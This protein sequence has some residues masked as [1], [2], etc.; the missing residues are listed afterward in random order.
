MFVGEAPGAE[1]DRQGLPFVGRAGQLLDELLEGIGLTRDDVF[2][3]NVL[4]C[5]PPGNRDPQPD[6]IE[7]CWP[8]LR[9]PDRADPA[10]RDRHARQLRDQAAHRQPDRDH[11]GPRDARRST[12]SAAARCS[13]CRSSIRR[14]RCARPS[15]VE[16]LREDFAKLPALL[17]EPLPELE[18]RPPRA[19]ARGDGRAERPTRQQLDLF[20]LTAIEHLSDSAAETEALGA[21]LAAG[22]RPGRRRPGQRRARR[23]QDDPDPRRLPG[24]RRRPSR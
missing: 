20:G 10:A 13:C 7:S 5:R 15:L 14:P 1:E 16:T 8:Y 23:G 3:A 22:L 17:S 2:I 11:Q 12:R 6:E 24:A 21:R 4:K 19:E 9:A 18:A